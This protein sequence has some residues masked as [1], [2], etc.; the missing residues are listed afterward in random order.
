[1]SNKM[2][3]T[4]TANGSSTTAG[5][6]GRTAERSAAGQ[7][8]PPPLTPSAALAELMP[9]LSAGSPADAG[10]PAVVSAAFVKPGRVTF[11]NSAFAVFLVALCCRLWFAWGGI[12][13]QEGT[14][15][16]RPDS[17]SYLAPAFSMAEFGEYRGPDGA[18]TAH[19]TPGFPAFLGV[20]TTFGVRPTC[21]AETIWISVFLLV[22]GALT[23]F[24]VYCACRYVSSRTCS[25][26]AA[27][28][29]ALNPT[30]IAHAPML[31]SDT[32]FTLIV[33]FVLFFFVSF[34]C[35]VKKDPFYYFSA[36]FLAAVA[37]LIRP[38]N[39]FF[40]LPLIVA[41]L[42]IDPL[43]RKK[44]LIYS[45]VTCVIFFVILFPWI[46][47]NHAIGAG[48]RLDSSSAST[49]VHNAAAVESVVSQND[50]EEMRRRYRESFAIEFAAEPLKY[51][52]EGARLDYIED[53]M[54]GKILKH[55]FLY[56]Y[57]TL[58][59]WVFLPDVPTLLEIQ[60]VTETERGTFDVLNREGILAAVCHYFE[61]N[62]KALA[63]TIPL[64][65]TV[66]V[67]YLA[68]VAGWITT[69]RKKQWLMAFLLIGFGLYYTLLAGPV[70]MPRYQLPALPVLAFFAAIAMQ[71][72][73]E[74]FR[75]EK[76]ITN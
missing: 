50:G 64:L 40:F 21:E 60:G 31:L 18:L 16:F 29:F 9:G 3:Q 75:K 76:K 27:L 19:R 43:S 37:A 23:V 52:S 25:A 10:A 55:P 70:Q 36:V 17:A 61:G 30:A 45:A 65:L 47:R 44:K 2:T 24:P 42:L 48:W 34:A 58:R 54:T 67:L 46:A 62:G 72:V 38:I 4:N 51:R 41:V 33:A 7:A 35:G 20:L 68:A 56:G 32:F 14:R 26:L 71:A 73:F 13:D 63:A 11:F 69:I 1:M 5:R 28:L 49:L 59:P 6:S 74:R 15:F 53:E 22:L 12:M 39:L 57:L 66:L 8:A